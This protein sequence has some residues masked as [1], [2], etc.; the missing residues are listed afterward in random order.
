MEKRCWADTYAFPP[1][2]ACY[3]Q[4]RMVMC[5]KSFCCSC[6]CERGDIGK[7]TVTPSTNVLIVMILVITYVCVR[8]LGE[9]IYFFP[10]F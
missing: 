1:C 6:L 3:L 7:S 5:G 10:I 4:L 9:G 8:N 2:L